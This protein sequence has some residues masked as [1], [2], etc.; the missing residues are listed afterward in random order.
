MIHVQNHPQVQITKE[1]AFYCDL[2]LEFKTQKSQSNH[3][4]SSGTGFLKPT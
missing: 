3:F 1:P 4:V 2:F